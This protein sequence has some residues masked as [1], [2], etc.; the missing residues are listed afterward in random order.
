MP[1]LVILILADV[2]RLYDVTVAWQ[3]AGSTGITILE[4]SGAARL[5][6]HLGAR[7]DLPLFP[8]MARLLAHQE[9]HHRMLMTVL[10]D[11]V[12]LAA[13]FDATE[14]VIGPLDSHHS[15]IIFAVPVLA[16]RGL[17]R[18]DAPRAGGAPS[19]GS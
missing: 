1:A 2:N 13:F 8:G 12:D 4:S 14:A 3:A 6:A 10:S 11:N 9:Q 17:D 16:V 7:D 18:P 15:G 19:P 5:Y